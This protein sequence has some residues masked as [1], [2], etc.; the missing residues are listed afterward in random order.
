MSQ[1]RFWSSICA[2]ALL[3]TS[4]MMAAD[5]AVL[6]ALKLELARTMEGLK[7][8]QVP[9]YFLSYSVT[10]V[11]TVTFASSFGGLITEDA[12]TNRILDVDL[13]VG[14]HQ[15]DNTHKVRGVSFSF[16]GGTRGVAL[17]MGNDVKALRSIV[18]QATDRAYASAVERLEKVAT[19][20]QVKVQE[21]DTSA[22]MS[23]EKAYTYVQTPTTMTF[24]TTMWRDR[25]RE[26][27]QV[28]V[29]HEGLYTGS[30]SFQAV[31]T[32]KTFVNSEGTVI[33]QYEPI[34]R[35]F[36]TVKSKA[37]DGMSLPLYEII[38]SIHRR[39]IAKL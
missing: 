15:L 17:P 27:S 11:S 5:D 1:N 37:E 26:L 16:G 31:M 14:D 9:P 30:V 34:F 22:D 21:E 32:V 29:G 28:F 19:N 4:P 36:T 13:R 35:M 2:L 20:M 8:E 39:S 6:T 33:R 12:K 18:W 3:A 25:V 38:L 23:M 10:E 24:D 7:S